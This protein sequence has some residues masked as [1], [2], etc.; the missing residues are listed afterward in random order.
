MLKRKISLPTV[1][2][3]NPTSGKTSVV[4]IPGG[5]RAHV[6]YLK[7]TADTGTNL[8]IAN[9]IGDIRVKLGGKVQRLHS[10]DELNKLNSVNGD[11]YAAQTV[12]SSASNYGQ[13]IPIFL[14]E[15]W[16]NSNDQADYLAWPSTKD[17]LIEVEVDCNGTPTGTSPTITIAASAV[18]DSLNQPGSD[19]TGVLISK[20][21]RNDYP[22]AA[23]LDITTLDKRDIYQGI[24]IAAANITKAIVKAGGTV[25][26]ELPLSE[27]VSMLKSYGLQTK[28]NYDL[29][30]DAEDPIQ[31]GLP[32]NGLNDLQ[33]R[34]EQSSAAVIRVL[35]QRLGTPE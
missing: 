32:A 31:N 35:A 26:H 9:W 11:S 28:F 30:I 24:Y 4:S 7:I 29:V 15:P 22:S 2:V 12:G 3:P 23:N 27:N 8:P 10:A 20:V 34:I 17:Q 18:V 16:R 14:A 5:L 21:F 19:K 25:V 13:I 6:I 33:L 1:T